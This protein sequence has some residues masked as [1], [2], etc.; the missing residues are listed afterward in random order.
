M[1]SN[2]PTDLH[3]LFHR[4]H[5]DHVP[6]SPRELDE[7]IVQRAREKAEEYASYSST[8]GFKWLGDGWK[9]AVAVFSV[10]VI[11]ISVTIQVYDNSRT[12]QFV[13][14][15]AMPDAEVASAEPEQDVLPAP[16]DREV[17]GLEE[18]QTQFNFA[19][20]DAPTTQ[21]RTPEPARSSDD[22]AAVTL[23][24]TE[25]QVRAQTG[26]SELQ[27]VDADPGLV[28][29]LSDADSLESSTALDQGAA[30]AD[31]VE[32]LAAAL[33]IV[34]AVFVD[35]SIDVEAYGTPDSPPTIEQLA[36]KARALVDTYAAVENDQ[37]MEQLT[38]AY[39]RYLETGNDSGLPLSMRVTIDVFEAWLSER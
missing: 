22:T 6:R 31:T 9:A 20:A 16:T 8:V 25:R 24:A 21:A 2:K 37:L 28:E 26:V 36:A 10:A 38:T 30:P 14:S 17:P 3:G 4:L 33:D 15:R 11:A 27:T 29:L 32:K 12:N 19:I 1:P 39:Q 34:E 23:L 5:E 35:S 7:R 13:T 18:R